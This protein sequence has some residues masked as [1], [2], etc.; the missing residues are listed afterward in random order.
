MMAYS[1]SGG[2]QKNPRFPQRKNLGVYDTK[3]RVL[4]VDD[5]ALMRQMLSDVLSLDEDIQVVAR[6]ANGEE[7]LRLLEE[8]Q[9]DVIVMDFAM[10]DA[11]GIDIVQEIR[12]Q[13]SQPVLMVSVHVQPLL[14]QW[15]RHVGA[16]G[17]LPK[18][19]VAHSLAPAIREV[20]EG[21]PFFGENNQ[22]HQQA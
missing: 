2:E 21:R 16:Q 15:A 6:A 7:A 4:I 22:W 5:H 20:S 1:S 13:W 19:S 8:V 17:Y 14:V 3:I 10:P 11:N 9:P 18:L 12:E